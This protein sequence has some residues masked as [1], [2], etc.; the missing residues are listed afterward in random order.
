MDAGIPGFAIKDVYSSHTNTDLCSTDFTR[1]FEHGAHKGREE[2]TIDRSQ[3]S[4][5]RT[6]IGGGGGKSEFPVSDC[7][8]DALTLLYYARRELGQG[9][10]PPA[11]RIL[12]GGIYIWTSGW[13]MQARRR[14]RWRASRWLPTK[15][16]VR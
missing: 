2:E 5:T 12:L 16:P 1:Q 3:E 14:F 13:I 8:K 10:V 4:V 9:R 15:S 7:M 6:T 11:Q